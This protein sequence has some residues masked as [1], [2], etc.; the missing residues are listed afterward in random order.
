MNG[1]SD[2]TI[3]EVCIKD[4]GAVQKLKERV[5]MSSLTAKCQRQ[6]WE[7]NPA[8]LDRPRTSNGWV[9]ETD[10]R[11]V[12]YLG[13][14]PLLFRFKNNDVTAAAACAFAVDPAH[15]GSC[16]KLIAA[17]FNQKK[18]DLLMVNTASTEA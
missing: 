4:W 2:A 16:L 1:T 6:L 12:G 8:K 11:I 14:I 5:G 17:F 18:I 3:R 9:M 10:G 15:R 13:S 7:T